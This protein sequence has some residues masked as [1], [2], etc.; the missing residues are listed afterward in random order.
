[1]KRKLRARNGDPDRKEA[2]SK[3]G[4]ATAIPLF[5]AGGKMARP[6]CRDAD[7]SRPQSITALQWNKNDFVIKNILN[8]PG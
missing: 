2:S 7:R 5:P 6:D 4:L 3:H 1:M 8:V